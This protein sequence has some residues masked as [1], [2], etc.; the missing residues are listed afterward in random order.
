[1]HSI[2]QWRSSLLFLTGIICGALIQRAS[3]SLIFILSLVRGEY[4]GNGGPTIS[5]VELTV[6]AIVTMCLSH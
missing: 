6:T 3:V 2:L 4:N 5:G 1:M